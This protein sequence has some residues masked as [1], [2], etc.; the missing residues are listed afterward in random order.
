MKTLKIGRENVIADEL[1]VLHGI[2]ELWKKLGFDETAKDVGFEFEKNE[3]GD[4]LITLYPKVSRAV[5]TGKITGYDSEFDIVARFSVIE[6][7]KYYKISFIHFRVG[8]DRY[9]KTKKQL[10]NWLT[11]TLDLIGSK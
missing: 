8:E 3:D 2:E 11:N 1:L 4:L 6:K 7:K 9:F 5:Y 10:H